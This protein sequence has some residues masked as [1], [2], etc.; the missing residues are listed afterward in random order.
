MTTRKYTSRS[1]QTTLTSAVTSG[2]AVLP[3]VAATTLLGGT[4]IT[5]GQTFTAV[6]DPD[7]ALE[8]IV[9]VTAVS[10]NN[11]TITRAIDGSSAQDHSAGAVVRHM[12][13]GRDLREAN[14]HIEK[15]T[16]VHGLAVGVTLV[17]DTATQTLTNK[18]LTSPTISGSPTITGLG[19]PSA[20]SD[21]VPK[22]YVDG[23]I[24]SNQSYAT[25]AATSATSAA[26]SAS[27][28]LTSQTAAA[29]SA[30]SAAASA[31]AAATSA[32]SA[33][34]S[35][36]SAATQA[37]AAATSAASAAAS[38]SAAATSAASAAISATA[39]A[40]SATSAAASATAAATSASSASTQAT[41]A[42]TSASSAAASATT[43]ANS[44]ATITTSANSAATS[45]NSAATS[46]TAAATSATSAAASATAAA[47]SATSAS[48]TLTSI[49]GLTGAGIVRDMGSITDADTT[50]TSYINIS[51]LTSQAQTSA[52]SA[53]TSASSAATSQTAAATSATSAAASATAAATSA[54]SAAASATAAATSAASAAVAATSAVQLSGGTMTGFLTLSAD[55]TSNLHAVTKQY[56]DAITAA[57]NFHA[58]VARASTA[59]L[60]G[61][62][63]NGT[64]GV[65]ATFTLTATGRLALDGGNVSTNDRVL[66][67]N[68]TTDLQ[69]GIYIVTNQG[70]GGVSAVLTR[71][72]DYDNNVEVSNGD[73]VFC[74]AGTQNAGVTFV[75]TSTNPVTIGTSS[76]TFSVYTSA[77]LPT[78]TGNA[79][80]YLT[81]DG[82]T[83][84]WG[85]VTTDPKADIFMMMGA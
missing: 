18:T 80:K 85:A 36:S 50:T 33:A 68:Q 37:T 5:T 32:A 24:T 31:T 61:T 28:A 15:S 53:A 8:E 20:S 35:A 48:N 34:T 14:E 52:T 1:Q 39:A 40:T 13:I 4:T 6:I 42:A 51:T 16:N 78:Q 21:A 82:T 70:S 64:S 57:I 9:D 38:T 81:T 49:T 12:I 10:G 60:T 58:P 74:T 77:S 72:T 25:A 19:T 41:A 22:S 63:N 67:K 47:T 29:T 27:S 44:V 62:Y 56:A 43:A 26:T 7:T 66:L 79:G 76:I 54:T 84:S 17:G 2:A 30:T 46:A 3:V 83:P 71:T 65:G 73:I 75:N 59:N 11:L 69:N 23:L 45:A 55:P